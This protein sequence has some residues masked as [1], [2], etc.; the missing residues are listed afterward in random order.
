MKKKPR[1]SLAIKITLAIIACNLLTAGIIA[2]SVGTSVKNSYTST[3]IEDAT[4]VAKMARLGISGD[5]LNLVT[6]QTGADENFLAIQE[7]LQQTS[8]ASDEIENIYVIGMRDGIPVYLVATEDDTVGEEI[9]AEYVEES[10]AAL[11]QDTYASGEIDEYDGKYVTTVYASV[12]DGAG[13]IAGTVA[14]D[15][16]TANI[17]HAR[18]QVYQRI[19]ISAIVAMILS[20]LLAIVISRGFTRALKTIH[21]K[22]QSLVSNNGDLTQKIETRSNDEIS[23]IAGS[24][25]DFLGYIRTIVM[26]ISSESKSLNTS[27]K[28]IQTI[29]NSTNEEIENVTATMEEMSASME[30]TSDNIGSVHEAIA[31][32]KDSIAKMKAEIGDGSEY[33]K[34]MKTRAEDLGKAAKTATA[35]AEHATEEMTVSLNDKIEKSKEI[36]NISKLTDQ[37]LSIA[38]QTNLLALNASIEAARAGEAGKGFAVVADEISK[39]ADNSSQTAKQ[40]QDISSHLIGS[41]NELIQESS[42]MLGFVK[43]KT[44]AG[45]NKLDE[46]GT[47]YETDATRVDDLLNEFADSFDA[48]SDQVDQIDASVLSIATMVRENVIGITD[49]AGSANEMSMNMQKNKIAVDQ[50]ANIVN[51]LDNE[52]VKFTI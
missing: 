10:R 1:I 21:D 34:S 26:N 48:I 17:V 14:L 18:N 13:D 9:E 31:Q 30:S 36:E 16:N 43:D 4:A 11:T 44:I 33:A 32:I 27:V 37:I 6:T 39:L 20:I 23:D 41:V 15:Y 51:N 19:A 38:S 2:N 42:G 7:N 5:Q 25:N 3:M 47:T 28:S 24:I 40:I 22:I 45:Y 50:N 12:Y 49:V 29:T 52:V 46:T 35:D 8:E